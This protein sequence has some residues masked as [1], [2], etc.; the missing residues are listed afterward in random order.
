NN[1]VRT[2]TQS[3][4]VTTVAGAIP[5]T[6]SGQGI[7]VAPT[8]VAVNAFGR[9]VFSD[10]GLDVVRRVMLPPPVGTLA[11][12]TIVAGAVGL[13]GSV[14]DYRFSARD[15]MA[16]LDWLSM[17]RVSRSS[18]T[19]RTTRLGE[20]SRQTK[21][22]LARCGRWRARRDWQAR[23]TALDQPHGSTFRA[24]S[25]STSRAC[26]TLRTLVTTRFVE[27]RQTAA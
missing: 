4:V 22:M 13:P 24:P 27:S 17:P 12:F 7:L 11:I 8:G 15:S 3:G 20:S 2:I 25:R 26:C 1:L 10:T 16:R 18:P 21:K 14:D 19:P 5:T 23:L 9:V 6:L